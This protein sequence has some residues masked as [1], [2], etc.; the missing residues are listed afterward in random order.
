MKMSHSLAVNG[1][2]SL[3][4][5]PATAEVAFLRAV[6]SDRKVLLPES[7]DIPIQL[8]VYAPALSRASLFGFV[9]LM[10][11][12]PVGALVAFSY[13]AIWGFFLTMFLMSVGSLVVSRHPHV[14]HPGR[15]VRIEEGE[16][17]PASEREPS[18]AI[19]G[20]AQ[21]AEEK[22]P[23]PSSAAYLLYL[24]LPRRDGEAILG[25]LEE[26]YSMCM[27]PA[28]GHR[29]ARFWFWVQV[30]RS[31]LPLLIL[32]SRRLATESAHS[33]SLVRSIASLLRRLT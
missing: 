28:F 25:D 31:I 12:G 10:A 30:L 6:T 16:I 14:L 27:V 22:A 18:Q 2:P 23:Y 13:S 9:A 5:D 4:I 17:R 33:Y 24:L 15:K 3:D 19:Q 21:Q 20:S 26:E 8:Q 32:S 29:R 11:A 1:E 7:P